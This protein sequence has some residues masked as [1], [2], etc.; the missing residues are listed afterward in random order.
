MDADGEKQLNALADPN[1]RAILER[2][3]DRPRSVNEIAEGLSVGRPAVSMH[4]RVLKDAGLV[5]DSP[6]GNKRIYRL[7]PQG[8][9]A[10]RRYFEGFWSRAL[11]D[12]VQATSEEMQCDVN[13]EQDIRVVK[14]TTVDLPVGR[15][16][17]LFSDLPRW[18]P[19]RTHHLAEPPG[20]MALLEPWVG[21]RWGERLPDGTLCDWGQVL[22]WDP[23]HRIVLTWQIGPDWRYVDDP[24][25]GSEV[26]I[27]FA[28]ESA[29]RTRIDFVHRRLERYGQDAEQM[30]TILD[31]PSA[32]GDVLYAFSKSV[33]DIER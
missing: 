5:K 25:F 9:E 1:R 33:N 16:F 29:E 20:T 13:T 3:A 4:L 32:A 21:G 7:D 10:L 18:W 12:Y 22:V 2:L 15:A 11:S 14:T 23:P 6:E 17:A 28:A 30:R 8:L 19:I 26:E 27:R 24:N 31:G